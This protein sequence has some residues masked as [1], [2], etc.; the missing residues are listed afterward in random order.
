LVINEIISFRDL[1]LVS[2]GPDEVLVI[3]CDSLGGIGTKP[4]DRIKVPED[5]VGKYTVRVGLMEVLASGAS[6]LVVVN[7]LSVEMDPTGI[8]ILKGIQQEIEASGL[9]ADIAVTG[10]TEENMET[11]QSGLGVTVIG[12][13][14][15]SALRLGQSRPGDLVICLG[16]PKVGEEVLDC[17]EKATP[18]LVKTL[19]EL[20]YVR[21]ILPVGSLGVLHEAKLLAQC[22]GNRLEA[23]PSPGIDL[24]QSAGP[25]TCVLISME[26]EYLKALMKKTSLPIFIIGRL[27]S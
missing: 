8:G 19:L 23:A 21:E 14:A 13:A 18:A 2:L 15:R 9:S 10:S 25:A 1:T 4:H 16:R 7:T 27:L 22:S 26:P 3:A 6:P 20:P 24:H 5:V 11:C 12:K 17:T